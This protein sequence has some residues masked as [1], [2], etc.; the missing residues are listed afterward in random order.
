MFGCPQSGI[1]DIAGWTD[2]VDAM[3]RIPN[4]SHIGI[5]ILACPNAFG[6][7]LG[8]QKDIELCRLLATFHLKSLLKERMLDLNGKKLHYLGG[9]HR[10]DLIQYY[11]I[12]DSLDTSSP[13][14]HGYQ[15]T[16]YEHG[17][18]PHGKTKV[19]VDFNAPF[20]DVGQ[21]HAIDY[22]LRVLKEHARA[23]DERRKFHGA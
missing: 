14:W 5:S 19:P 9:G 15:L 20:P 12:A 17:F 1:G 10:V 23:A 13:G 2:A 18:L 11:D 8:N 16:K 21:L 4:V 6:P 3:T 22:N 7:L